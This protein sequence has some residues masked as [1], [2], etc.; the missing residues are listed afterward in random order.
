MRKARLHW[1]WR[2]AIAV[3]AAGLFG[4]CYGYAFWNWSVFRHSIVDPAWNLL[5]ALGLHGP[6]AYVIY[7]ALL[8]HLIPAAIGVGTYALLS[9]GFRRRVAM[10]RETRCRCC[11]YILRGITEPRCPECGERI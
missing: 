4:G 6:I 5:A 2:A 3:A 7:N 10:H 11:G 9:G 8:W 1:F